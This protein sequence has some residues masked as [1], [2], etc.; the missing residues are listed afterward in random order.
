MKTANL[1]KVILFHTKLE[2]AGRKKSRLKKVGIC[3]FKGRVPVK[4]LGIAE[5]LS[6]QPE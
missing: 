3:D 6:S 5:E 4:T 1:P 2:D